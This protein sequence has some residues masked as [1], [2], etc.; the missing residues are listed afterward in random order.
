[1][2]CTWRDKI[3]HTDPYKYLGVKIDEGHKQMKE[4]NARIG[5]Y[6]K[7]FLMRYPLLKEKTIPREVKVTVYN[8]ILRRTLLYGSECWAV[9]SKT[10]SNLQAI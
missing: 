8:A 7:S 10:R 9:T 1:M 4:I 3:Y 5:K 6:T 2:M